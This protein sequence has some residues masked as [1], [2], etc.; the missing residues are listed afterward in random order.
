MH[1]QIIV[2][3]VAVLLAAPA[4]VRADKLILED[5]RTLSGK[6]TVDR[7]EDTRTY[8]IETDD[9]QTLTFQKD[10]VKRYVYECPLTDFEV[11]DMYE[12]W[13]EPVR[14]VLDE[15]EPAQRQFLF[16][17][18]DYA[19]RVYGDL[20]ETPP[21]TDKF[22]DEWARYAAKFDA[23]RKNPT[24][25]KLVNP[26]KGSA[27]LMDY[28]RDPPE[29]REEVAAIIKLAIES[30]EECLD[31]AQSTN[32]LVRQLP[33]EQVKGRRKI[34]NARAA[35]TKAEA[36]RYSSTFKDA[37]RRAAENREFAR[38]AAKKRAE[39]EHVAATA[40]NNLEKKIQNADERINIFAQQRVVTAGHLQ[41]A[42][43]TVERLGYGE[44]VPTASS[45]GGQ[46]TAGTTPQGAVPVLLPDPRI[47]GDFRRFVSEHHSNA[48]GLTSVGLR[49]LRAKTDGDIQRLFVGKE[50]ALQVDVINIEE[51]GPEGYLLTGANSASWGVKVMN[52]VQLEFAGDLK[53]TLIKCKVGEPVELTARIKGVRLQPGLPG[54]ESSPEGANVS[55]TGDVINVKRGCS[56]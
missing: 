20:W 41:T 6:V 22:V 50:F 31:S 48:K 51:R 53:N 11:F 10:E 30:F 27:S 15:P 16:V 17:W 29:G 24:Y 3:G 42:R 9:G 38:R 18:R 37:S 35:A 14:A 28:A 7:D 19:S 26:R 39:I 55:L 34:R 56:W 43:G 45:A 36:R 1:R 21:H 25:K 52:Q 46:S 54:I 8:T 32:A 12:E 44:G 33:K 49:E 5:G 4:G 47:T 13:V 23:V 2:L 40:R